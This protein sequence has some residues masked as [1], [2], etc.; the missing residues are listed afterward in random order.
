M[1]RVISR[2]VFRVVFRVV[3]CVVFCVV[4]CSAVRIVSRVVSRIVCRL[5]PR[6]PVPFVVHGFVLL[7][8][9]LLQF[10]VGGIT[11]EIFILKE[12]P[13]RCIECIC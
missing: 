12:W 5:F 1:F 4:C 10:I 8:G 7:L 13:F 11:V 3:V 2:V 6:A 9:L